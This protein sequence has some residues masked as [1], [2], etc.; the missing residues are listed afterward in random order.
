MIPGFEHSPL[1]R[2]YRAVTE[3]LLLVW[4]GDIGRARLLLRQAA[5]E[6]PVAI[7]FAGLG[8]VLARR[9]DLAVLGAFSPIARALTAV[10]PPAA[11]MDVLVDRAVEAF[12]NGSFE[13][14]AGAIGL[15]RDRGE[16]QARFAV[17]GWRRSCSSPRPDGRHR[18]CAHRRRSSPTPCVTPSRRPATVPGARSRRPCE[19]RH[20]GFGRPSPAAASRRCSGSGPGC[21]GIRSRPAVTLRRPRLFEAAGASAWGVPSAGVC[22][23]WRATRTSRAARI[24]PCAGA[25]GRSG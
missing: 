8:V 19:R 11:D 6:L 18:R 17:P 23:G 10:L 25:P 9:L 22:S 2:A 20:D 14:A 16:P 12:L 15:W 3:V 13:A 24:S 21:T 4:R 7:P 5:V 1:G